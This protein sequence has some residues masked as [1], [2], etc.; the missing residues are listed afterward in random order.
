MSAAKCN[1]CRCLTPQM[2]C[3]TT[4]CQKRKN[5]KNLCSSLNEYEM[6]WSCKLVLPLD[7]EKSGWQY[8]FVGK[9]SKQDGHAMGYPK[10]HLC[11]V[12]SVLKASV[13][14]I[15]NMIWGRISD[16]PTGCNSG[17]KNMKKIDEICGGK[18]IWLSHHFSSFLN[19][20]GCF[21]EVEKL[22][23]IRF[24]G[25]GKIRRQEEPR[26]ASLFSMPDVPINTS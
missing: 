14:W 2:G 20:S 1:M 25:T 26:P 13:E 12:K 3:D 17:T 8:L 10:S 21:A 9:A 23:V 22:A 7:S 5:A 6:A 15:A 19:L 4:A 16:T 24:L 18:M 11:V